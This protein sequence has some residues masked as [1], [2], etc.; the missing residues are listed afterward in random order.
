MYHV[1]N[2]I[3]VLRILHNI[4]HDGQRP[5]KD[6]KLQPLLH[7]N[8]SDVTMTEH[9]GSNDENG[10]FIVHVKDP[11]YGWHRADTQKTYQTS[12]EG[13]LDNR[14]TQSYTST[15]GHRIPHTKKHLQG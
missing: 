14:E 9:I 10:H 15:N 13:I 2:Q 7:H 8:Y 6:L 12:S 11:K 5:N 4:R 1:Q 3:H